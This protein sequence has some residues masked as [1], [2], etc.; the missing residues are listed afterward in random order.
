M[1][2]NLKYIAL[3]V[4]RFENN[5]NLHEMM[6]K[7][8]GRLQKTDLHVVFKVIGLGWDFVLKEWDSVVID[9]LNKKKLIKISLINKKYKIIKLKLN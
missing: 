1:K 5:P 6:V 4:V 2:L 7:G 8:L 9:L 3:V